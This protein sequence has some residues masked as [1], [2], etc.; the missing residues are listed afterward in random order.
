MIGVSGYQF[1]NLRD[2]LSSDLR[3]LEMLGAVRSLD[4]PDSW[5][6]AGAVRN[7]V[8]DHLHGY[9]DSTPLND[10]DVIYFDPHD[11]DEE[12]EKCLEDQL[13]QR[14]PAHPW[15]V[16]NQVRMAKRNGDAPY[17]STEHALEHWCE[18]PT[19]VGVRLNANDHIEI[20][21]PFGLDDLL[22]LIV[23]PTPFAKCHP[24]KLAQYRERM[25]KKNWPSRWPRIRVLEF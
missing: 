7:S 9:D 4:L 10:V 2:L 20:I 16:K 24:R 18:T 1:E 22:G 12:T 15:S 3:I 21:A 23:R 14:L 6:T 13:H 5:I 11:T 8:W 19:A 25:I 17:H